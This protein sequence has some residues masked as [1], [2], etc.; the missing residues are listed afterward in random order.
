MNSGDFYVL[1]VDFDP[2]V[3]HTSVPVARCSLYERQEACFL[4]LHGSVE[5]LVV[6][7]ICGVEAEVS[8]CASVT[9][10]GSVLPV[11]VS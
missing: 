8:Q 7:K 1:D 5:T 6:F 2:G 11:V 10:A 4:S 9:G 3:I